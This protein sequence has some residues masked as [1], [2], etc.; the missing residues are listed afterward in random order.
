M[1]HKLKTDRNES[2]SDTERMNLLD[3]TKQYE[4]IKRDSDMHTVAHVTSKA[5]KESFITINCRHR[6]KKKKNLEKNRTKSIGRQMLH[7]NRPFRMY[8]LNNGI[9]WQINHTFFHVKWI[10][11][12]FSHFYEPL[13][14]STTQ[15]SIGEKT[16]EMFNSH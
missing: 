12:H 6:K 5:S 13:K 15:Q 4:T 16:I 1:W 7:Q 2:M 8:C 11:R 9:Y 10:I 14:Q 3:L